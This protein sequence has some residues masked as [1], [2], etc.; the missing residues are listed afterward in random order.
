MDQTTWDAERAQLL[1][2]R[3]SELGL[4]VRG[5]RVEALAA[6]LHEELSARDISFRP[7]IYLS[8]EWGCPDGTP[9]IGVPFYLADP[10]LERIEAEH[11]GSVESDDEAMRYLRHEAGH[12][13]N[14]AFRIHEHPE[15]SGLFGDYGRPYEESYALDPLSRDYVRHILGWYAQKHPDEDFAETFA[16]WLTP[17]TAWRAEYQE[18][19]ALRKLEWVDARMGE[20]G[21]TPLSSPGLSDDDVPVEAMEWTVAEHYADDDRFP[22]LDGRQ[23]D[24]DLRRLF[25]ARSVAPDGEPAATWIMRHEGELVARLTHWCG[26]SPS[27]VRALMRT[28]ASRSAALELRAFGLEASTL[29]ELTAFSTAVVLHWR[30]RALSSN[31]TSRSVT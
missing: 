29:I 28:L 31:H 16:V 23:F 20:H 5:S 27:I 2:R 7:T 25:A 12:A 18:W 4:A 6:R 30:Y 11:A 10:R 13:I 26:S 3:I 21:S 15:F 17:D 22:V 1:G 19:G 8:D 14:Y 9:V 24:G